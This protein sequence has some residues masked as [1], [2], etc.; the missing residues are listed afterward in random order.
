MYCFGG[1]EVEE[2]SVHYKLGMGEE[3]DD[4]FAKEKKRNEKNEI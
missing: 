3:L 4:V 2:E 1:V